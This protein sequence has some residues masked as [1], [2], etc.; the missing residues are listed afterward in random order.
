MASLANFV[1]TERVHEFDGYSITGISTVTV[2][3]VSINRNIV[4]FAGVLETVKQ[5]F[6]GRSLSDPCFSV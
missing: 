2:D 1:I 4:L 3:N 5:E 6:G